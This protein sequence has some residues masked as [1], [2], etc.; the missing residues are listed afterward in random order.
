MKQKARAA[1]FDFGGTIDTDGVHWSE[2]FW[3]YYQRHKLPVEKKQYEQAYLR[4]ERE[5]PVRYDM[6]AMTFQKTLDAQFAM[7]FE[8]LGLTGKANLAKTMS[9][10][11]YA[12]VS[13][14][15]ERAK[16]VLNGLS[17]RYR[18][19]LVSNFYGNLEVVCNEFGLDTLFSV[20]IDSSVV[21]VQKPDPKIWAMGIEKLSVKPEDAFVIGDAYDR[22]IVPAKS[23][24]C[25]TIWL[26]GKSWK[27]PK[28]TPAA[29]YTIGK[30]EELRVILG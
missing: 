24:G 29:D 7:Q 17:A 3:E 2:K 6:S 1:L 20:K 12:E 30:F 5:L 28:A 25:T 27:M 19:G 23:L 13:A 18:L 8:Y 11:C 26:K 16:I 22:D 21:G 15:I 9:A 10:E 4:E 14:I